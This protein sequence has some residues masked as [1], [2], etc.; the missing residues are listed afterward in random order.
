M[1]VFESFMIMRMNKMFDLVGPLLKDNDQQL[2][3]KFPKNT[4][5]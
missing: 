3:L 5:M 4:G 2:L 1:Y